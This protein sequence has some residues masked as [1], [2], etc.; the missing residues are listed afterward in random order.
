M[1]KDLRG[2]YRWISICLLFC[3]VPSFAGVYLEVTGFP[4]Y[5][6]QNTQVN[7]NGGSVDGTVLKNAKGFSYDLRMT[8]GYLI[9]K[10][11][12]LGF[13]YNMGYS[14]TKADATST[15]AS[16]DKYS[17]FKEFGISGGVFLGKFR[18]I[19]SY[20]WGGTMDYQDKEINPDGTTLVDINIHNGG[21]SGFQIIAGYDIDLSKVIKIGPSL[22]YRNMTYKTQS[23]TDPVGGSGY[24]ETAFTTNATFSNLTPMLS[25]MFD[26]GG[27]EQKGAGPSAR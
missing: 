5:S 17:K 27:S 21:G 15:T 13:T 26:F 12:L 2:Q 7:P 8:T 24:A 20:L 22:V 4:G 25:L 19:G 9:K 11:Y 14:P 1:K 23:R 18:L 3:S 16:L 6:V 10:K